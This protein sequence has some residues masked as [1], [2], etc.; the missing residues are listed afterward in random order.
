MRRVPH[1]Q[2]LYQL[3]SQEDQ[4]LHHVFGIWNQDVLK[5]YLHHAILSAAIDEIGVWCNLRPTELSELY[6]AS[7]R[8]GT[9]TGLGIRIR[10]T[11]ISA[12]V[13]AGRYPTAHQTRQVLVSRNAYTDIL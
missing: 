8:A 13:P 1:I 4:V 6:E 11:G 12:A 9:L 3:Q 7:G 5:R 2:C 10:E